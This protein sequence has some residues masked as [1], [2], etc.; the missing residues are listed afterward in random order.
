MTDKTST[1]RTS[2]QGCGSNYGRGFV[3]GHGKLYGRGQGHWF[4]N[5]KPK[6]WG[7]C[8]PLGSDAYYIWDAIQAGKYTKTK[9]A[10]LNYIQGN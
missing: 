6:V 4:N 8:D 1:S 5:T 3:R 10:I 9:E 2:Y 7:K